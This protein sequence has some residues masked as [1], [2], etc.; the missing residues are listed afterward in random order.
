MSRDVTAT[1]RVQLHKDFT[2][3]DAAAIAS[4]LAELG[5]S[6]VYC[7]PYLQARSGSTHGYDVVDHSALNEELGG[8][9][10]HDRMIAALDAAG[11]GHVLDIVPNHMAVTDA[12]NRWW[13]DVLKHGAAS[14]YAAFFDIDWDPPEARVKQH[15]LVPILGDHYG[16]VLRSGDLVLERRDGEVVARYHEHVLPVA[17]GT[18]PEDTDLGAVARDPDALHRVM[19]AQHYRLAYWK[20]AGAELNYRRFFAIN[21]LAALRSENPEV[22]EATHRLVLDLVASGRL[23]GIRVDHVDGLRYPSEYLQR[24]RAAV[25]ADHPIWVEKI[26]EGDETLPDA[27]PVDGT[28]GYEFLI[29][30]QD[31]FV[32]PSGEKPLTDLYVEV[33]GNAVPEDLEYR[34]KV[35]VMKTELSPDIERLT[36]L[37]LAV[38]EKHRDYRDFTRPEIRHAIR[39][40]IAAFDVYRTYADARARTL[41]VADGQRIN[42]AVERATARRADLD[43]ELFRFL[44]DLLLLRHTGSEEEAF[45]M[46]FQQTTGPVMA[47]GIEDTFF[48]RYNRLIALNEV[49]G[50]PS[51]FG[52]A[53]DAW[54]RINAHVAR[55]WPRTLL[56]TSTHDTKRSEDVRARVVLLAEIPELWAAAVDRWMKHNDRYRRDGFP[57]RD[58]EYLLYQ[59]LVGAWP[60]DVDRIRAYMEKA[61]KEA[62]VHTSW[63]APNADYDAALRDF[64][65]AVM[66]DDWF[67]AELESFVAPLVEPGRVNS[68]AWTLL[69]LTAPGVPDIYQ[70]CDVW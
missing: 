68:L 5:I 22:F 27:W 65:G 25:G 54:H 33:S 40:T 56:A 20:A 14:R 45:A 55:R 9:A 61:T 17:P 1:Y 11:I 58:A 2:F 34:S 32:H 26:L 16:R 48:Y 19:D 57:D 50:S 53:V 70:G 67:R 63:I 21:E 13:W 69:K 41:D 42:G 23:D 44:R 31:L 52:G 36:E 30:T 62:K 39:E 66:N 59:T 3:D 35:H 29:R 47:K 51:R 46:R 7:S 24:L 6:H 43:P 15:I 64:V 4:Y 10:G 12:R 28:T 38:C 37:M 18:V 60:I 49:G 8:S